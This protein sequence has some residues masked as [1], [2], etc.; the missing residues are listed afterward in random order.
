MIEGKIRFRVQFVNKKDGSVLQKNLNAEEADKT[1]ERMKKDFLGDFLKAALLATGQEKQS[2]ISEINELE[3]VEVIH[4]S[5]G[6]E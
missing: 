4:D 2:H 1:S 6:W 5:S 3:D